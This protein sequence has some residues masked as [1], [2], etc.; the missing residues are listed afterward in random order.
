MSNV[1]QPVT[2]GCFSA[3]VL[4]LES[5]RLSDWEEIEHVAGLPNLRQLQLSDNAL[6]RAVYRTS[7]GELPLGNSDV[8]HHTTVCVCLWVRER[9]REGGGTQRE[10]GGEGNTHP[11]HTHTH[12][13]IH[14][15][16]HT[17]THTADLKRP[18]VSQRQ[19][20]M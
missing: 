9:E 8:A 12:T 7:S 13:Y 14:T 6:T 11:T 16:P 17:R 4:D 1:S 10:G 2:H 18:V 5:N 3:Q 15:K 19:A 20:I